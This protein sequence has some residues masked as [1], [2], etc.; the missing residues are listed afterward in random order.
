MYTYGVVAEFYF[1]ENVKL[2]FY[3]P[4]LTPAL[5]GGEWS[6]LSFARFILRDRAP[7]TWMV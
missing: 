3:L 4:F 5:D 6:A 2:S 1:P 7:G